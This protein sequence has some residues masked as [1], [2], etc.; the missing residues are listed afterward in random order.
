MKCKKYIDNFGQTRNGANLHSDCAARRVEGSRREKKRRRKT[1]TTRAEA[2]PN[3]A[4]LYYTLK[5]GTRET[6][7]VQRQAPTAISTA[8]KKRPRGQSPNSFEVFYF[9]G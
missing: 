7:I 1:P 9:L 4:N 6:R 5:S 2:K 3:L 8:T